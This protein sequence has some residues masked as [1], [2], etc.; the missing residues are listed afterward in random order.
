[1]GVLPSHVGGAA[2]RPVRVGLAGNAAGQLL[3]VG[4]VLMFGFGGVGACGSAARGVLAGL[5]C[6][7]EWGVVWAWAHS[8]AHSALRSWMCMSHL[9]ARACSS[10]SISYSSQWTLSLTFGHSPL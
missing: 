6:G 5:A 2:G 1:M 4:R 3:G 10:W 8:P 9:M 7:W